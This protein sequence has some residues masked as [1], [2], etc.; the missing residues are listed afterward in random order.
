MSNVTQTETVRTESCIIKC[1]NPSESRGIKKME[2]YRREDQ[3]QHADLRSG[4]YDNMKSYDN[5]RG[6]NFWCQRFPGA[7]F[8]SRITLEIKT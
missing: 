4:T 3:Q 2:I 7:V 6:H 8:L 5:D 1:R